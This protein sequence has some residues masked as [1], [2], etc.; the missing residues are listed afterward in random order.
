ME[1]TKSNFPD[2]LGFDLDVQVEQHHIDSNQWCPIA[3]A[4]E[5]AF[6]KRFQCRHNVFVTQ[7]SV[8]ISVSPRTRDL[9][10]PSFSAPLPSECRRFIEGFDCRTVPNPK[11]FDTKLL[12]RPIPLKKTHTR[13]RRHR[14]RRGSPRP[15][16]VRPTAD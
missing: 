15:E 10:N 5:E 3:L 7:L 9:S 13:V 8:L 1:A 2:Q 14:A 12:F 4:V 11:T 16:A 6:A